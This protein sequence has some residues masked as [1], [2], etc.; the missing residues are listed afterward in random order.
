MVNVTIKAAMRHGDLHLAAKKVGSLIALAK[1]LDVPYRTVGDWYRYRS[2]PPAQSRLPDWPQ[3]RIDGLEK[4]LFDLT[5]K[6]LDELFPNEV[7]NT[8]FLGLEKTFESTKEVEAGRLIAMANKVRGI[9]HREPDVVEQ[10]ELSEAVNA[11]LG[12]LSFRE[13][14]VLKL[15]FGLGGQEPMTLEEVAFVFKFT[16]ERVRQIESKAMRKLKYDTNVS[17]VSHLP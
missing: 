11:S 10:K 8:A 12:S 6:L 16:R 4:K 9:E 7:R 15:R 14:E 5:G 3:V 13:R 17:L 2:C 1:H